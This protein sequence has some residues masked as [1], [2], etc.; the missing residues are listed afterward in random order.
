MWILRRWVQFLATILSNA[1]LVFPFTR[2]I[3]QGR[4]KSMCVPGLNCYS[5]PAATGACPLGSMQTFLAGIKPGL[6]TGRFHV[7]LYVIGYLG[8]IG[9]LVGRMLDQVTQDEFDDLLKVLK[10]HG[11]TVPSALPYVFEYLDGPSGM[12][13]VETLKAIDPS[14]RR[15]WNLFRDKEL[16]GAEPRERI[17]A[18]ER[19]LQRTFGAPRR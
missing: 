16:A 9:S 7:G 5:C 2:N 6:E 11:P 1:W 13:V 15:S 10:R 18:M 4:L 3:Y 8:I 17:L 19:T 14:G 12:L